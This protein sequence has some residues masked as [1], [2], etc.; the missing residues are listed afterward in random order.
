M[1]QEP[2]A[3][4]PIAPVARSDSGVWAGGGCGAGPLCPRAR[5]LGG[6]GGTEAI[7]RKFRRRGDA[8][9][10][11]EFDIAV[12]DASVVGG[13][14][15]GKRVISRDT[16]VQDRVPVVF[17]RTDHAAQVGDGRGIEHVRE[18]LRPT[19]ARGHVHR[20]DQVAFVVEA[21]PRRFLDRF[22]R[23]RFFRGH[24]PVHLRAHVGGEVEAL[25]PEP[26]HV[27]ERV[28][29]GRNR[30]CSQCGEP[31]VLGRADFSR[32]HAEQV[33][34][35]AELVDDGDPSVTVQRHVEY[36]AV[37]LPV[38]PQEIRPGRR[39]EQESGGA[40]A[41]QPVRPPQRKSRAS[42]A[43][44]RSVADDEC[45]GVTGFAHGRKE[46]LGFL[47]G[48]KLADSDLACLP[49]RG[50][51]DDGGQVKPGGDRPP[52]LV[53]GV[54]PGKGRDLDAVDVLGL[55][56]ALNPD[57]DFSRN[58]LPGCLRDL[59]DQVEF[60]CGIDLDLGGRRIQPDSY[61]WPGHKSRCRLGAGDARDGRGRKGAGGCGRR[62]S[63]DLGPGDG[64][65]GCRRRGGSTGG[66]GRGGLS[67][68]ASA[69]DPDL[70][71]VPAGGEKHHE[72][73]QDEEL[74]ADLAA[75]VEWEICGRGGACHHR[76][77]YL[78]TRAGCVGP[79]G[80]SL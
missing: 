66:R 73:D 61:R 52:Q 12:G 14:D 79:Y 17:G 30:L 34:L 3:G 35:H 32:N 26:A 25:G 44:G 38:Q 9:D 37:W 58:D 18:V 15:L 6:Q 10:G 2:G 64:G 43:T 57:L 75:P 68:L 24:T 7:G 22:A 51:A 28:G 55:P 49:G 47:A 70:R 11:G 1:P 36:T 33:L 4:F 78:L 60:T 13:E 62:W 41:K 56:A 80:R 27:L 42:T 5:F 16:R 54:A 31:G 77:K 63:V 8:E 76:D 59:L 23:G 46:F 65:G 50:F 48:F 71:L 19:T 74:G 29:A 72:Q 20:V 45:V 40:H 69:R 39:D 21:Q 53:G 67:G